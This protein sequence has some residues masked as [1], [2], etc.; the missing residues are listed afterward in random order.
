M[1]GNGCESTHEVT[2]ELALGVAAGE[3]RARAVRHLEGCAACRREVAE[4]DDVVDTVMLLAPEREPPVG[5]E[6]R[7]VA[8]VTRR[9]RGAGWRRVLAYAVAATLAAAATGVGAYVVTEQDRTVAAQFRT[10]LE[11]AGGRYFGVEFLHGPGGERAGHVFVYRGDPSW[12]FAVLPAERAGGF[13]VE[14][15]TRAGRRLEA[16]TI[17]ITS[18]RNAAGVVLPADLADL[19]SIHLVPQDG[20]SPLEAHLPAPP[21]S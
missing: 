6:S 3:R 1:S 14:V 18:E 11:R 16:G 21:A 17:E 8:A 19:E 4:L 2:A 13:D 15:V 20:G 10:A 7:V 12:A 9:R 5:F